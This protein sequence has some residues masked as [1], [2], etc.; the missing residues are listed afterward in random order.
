LGG[1]YPS[2]TAETVYEKLH[3]TF[4]LGRERAHE[5]SGL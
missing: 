3:N 1:E 5:L 4:G 2:Q